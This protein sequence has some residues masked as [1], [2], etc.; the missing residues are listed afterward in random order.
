MPFPAWYA[1]A[2]IAVPAVIVAPAVCS[3]RIAVAKRPL[4][5]Q[6]LLDT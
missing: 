6:G 5:K 1:S 3:F 2:N 4:F